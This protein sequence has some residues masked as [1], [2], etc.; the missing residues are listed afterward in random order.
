MLARR[1]AL[2]ATEARASGQVIQKAFIA[3]AEFRKA[4][5][6]AL[7]APIHNE[8]DTKEVFAE[9]LVT[10]KTV[11][12]PAVCSGKLEFRQVIALNMLQNGAFGIPEPADCC[13]VHD[14]RE[15]DLIVIPGIAFDVTGK[16]VG[17]GKG[18]YDK[19]LHHL[20]GQG[21]L[22]GFCYDFQLVE[23][24]AGEPHD[25]LMDLLITEK[26]VICPRD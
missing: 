10:S 16:R 15:V 7:Y 22:V 12:Y 24:I 21:K 1:K 5:A 3:S 26:R 17:Y 11:L 6:V 8:V 19:T 20:E 18:Y 2:P 25:V 9:A 4:R 23:S 13:E 14:S